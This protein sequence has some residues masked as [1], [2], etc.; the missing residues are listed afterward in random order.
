MP[1]KRA[2]TGLIATAMAA[3]ALM[4]SL[5]AVTPTSYYSTNLQ[6]ATQTTAALGSLTAA[7]ASNPS[8]DTYHDI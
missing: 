4:A 5:T 2:V 1:T 3:G 8:P 7:S 6:A